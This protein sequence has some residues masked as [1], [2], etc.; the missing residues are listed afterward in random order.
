MSPPTS[1]PR[2][3]GFTLVELLMVIVVIGMLAALLLPAIG[4]AVK[5]ARNAAV[6]GEMNQLAQALA[7]FKS[8]FGDYPPSRILLCED[9]NYSSYIGQT[10]ATSTIFATTNAVDISTAQLA[11]RSL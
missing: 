11:Q 9:G 10:A 1:R 6:T 4:N 7:D 3:P 5:S 8:K 2:R